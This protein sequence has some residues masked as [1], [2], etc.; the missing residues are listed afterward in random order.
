MAAQLLVKYNAEHWVTWVYWQQLFDISIKDVLLEVN[1]LCCLWHTCLSEIDPLT[2]SSSFL[3]CIRSLVKFFITSSEWSVTIAWNHLFHLFLNVNPV[4]TPKI[5]RFTIQ[6]IR[7]LLKNKPLISSNVSQ[8]KS[9]NV[10]I[11][12]IL[13]WY[14]YTWHA[15]NQVSL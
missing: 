1:N 7:A 8:Y 5:I 3:K 12:N 6:S 9:K 14:I 13:T 10:A 4:M 2:I 11:D 15:A